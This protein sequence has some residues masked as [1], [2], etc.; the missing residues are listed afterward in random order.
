[1]SSDTDK[2]KL[3]IPLPVERR[4]GN[5]SERDQRCRTS[6]VWWN[7]KEARYGT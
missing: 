3:E 6:S 1:M 4:T 2:G 5:E 7:N